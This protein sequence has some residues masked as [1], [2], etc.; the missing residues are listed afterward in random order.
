MKHGQQ[1]RQQR[2]E[3]SGHLLLCGMN[4]MDGGHMIDYVHCHK[5]IFHERK[6]NFRLALLYYKSFLL[7]LIG[8]YLAINIPHTV[9]HHFKYL[10]Q[11][12][13]GIYQGWEKINF[14]WNKSGK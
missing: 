13:R 11:K 12:F 14:L 5:T 7:P 1:Y 6:C 4:I 2:M 8:A 10:N 9:H 3:P